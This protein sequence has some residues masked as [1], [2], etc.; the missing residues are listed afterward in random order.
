MSVTAHHRLPQVPRRFIETHDRWVFGL[1]GVWAIASGVL[2]SFDYTA[3]SQVWAQQVWNAALIVGGLLA[4]AFALVQHS[5]WLR[6][7]SNAFL[8][9]ACAGRGAGLSLALGKLYHW[10]DG[11]AGT[12]SVPRAVAG[13]GVWWMIAFLLYIVWRS[14]LPDGHSGR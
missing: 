12:I 9:V 10:I 6:A 4:I 3:T 1:V 7:T 14:R 8:V 5:W 11:P 2:F 13:I